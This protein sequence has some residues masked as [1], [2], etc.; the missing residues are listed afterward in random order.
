M[1]TPTERGRLTNT[2]IRGKTGF[3]Q[4]T[5]C[6]YN[7]ICARMYIVLYTTCEYSATSTTMIPGKT[8]LRRQLYCVQFVMYV[9]HENLTHACNEQ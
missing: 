8:T 7:G 4:P 9:Q 1:L 3:G 5:I 2:Q 6:M